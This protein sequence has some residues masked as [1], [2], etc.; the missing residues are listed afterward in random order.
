MIQAFLS[1][2]NRENLYWPGDRWLIGVSGGVDSVCL[3]TLARE[4]GISFMIAHANFQLRGRESDADEAFVMDLAD[5]L[6]V[7][8][9]SKKFDTRAVAS[10][11]KSSIQEAARSLRYD[12]FEE[13]RLKFDLQYI[14]VAH[15]LD[16]QVETLFFN[17]VRG[18]GISG[19][20]GMLPKNGRVIRPLLF[21]TREELEQWAKAQKLTW[22]E[23][24]S[25]RDTKYTRN[26]IRHQLIPLLRELNP[27]LHKTLSEN[28]RV[29][30]DLEQIYRHQAA[31][32]K[33]RYTLQR[34]GALYIPVRKL[35]P[36][37]WARSVLYELLSPC[38]FTR[39]SLDH[40]LQW[41]SRPEPGKELL[42]E[43]YRLVCDRR[44]LI[45]TH[46][47]SAKSQWI[48]I[49]KPSGTL[50]T[51]GFRIRM[52]VRPVGRYVISKKPGKASLD[53]E[54]LEFPLTLRPWRAGDY[55]YPYGLGRPG[56]PSKPAKKKVSDYL[57][58][59]KLDALEKEN[60]WVLI[61]GQKIAWLV[62]HRIDHRFR[63]TEKT[64]Q[65]LSL[66]VLPPLK[67]KTAGDG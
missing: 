67:K 34:G 61:S 5:H 49:E 39:D 52:A 60:T 28:I 62:G 58:G 35:A 65:V 14:A 29:F 12:W 66:Q 4:A 1:Y 22:R 30:L 25:N 51:P 15:H 45:L 37:P 20:R 31:Q 38:G 42:S 36:V 8:A 64:R 18:T 10:R 2:L 9:F 50:T 33:K 43:T 23:D 13:L 57:G 11:Q 21:A 6:K 7:P 40:A 3:A 48:R 56:N 46:R 24:S 63:I 32:W 44:F 55:F 26:K 53:L 16:D 47:Q 17:L 27:G 54:K 41:L 19:L 59:L